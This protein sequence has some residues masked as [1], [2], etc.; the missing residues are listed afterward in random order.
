MTAGLPLLFLVEDD[1]QVR[2]TMH[3]VL[4]GRGYA[5]RSYSA[6]TPA[7]AD[8]S[9][10]KATLLVAD[11]RLPDGDGLMIR[12]AMKGRGW[13]GASILITGYGEQALN[14]AGIKAGN[15]GAE[16]AQAVH[17]MLELDARIAAETR[18]DAA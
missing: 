14:R 7:L 12:S 16:A 17:Q 2:R 5:V 6:A 13:Q 9:L 11:Y 3:L 18:A 4:Q 15:K 8:P 1:D 10:T